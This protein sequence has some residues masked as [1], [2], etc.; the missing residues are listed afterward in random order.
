MRWVLAGIVFALLV[1]LAVVTVAIKAQNVQA[2]ARVE[3]LTFDEQAVYVEW[4]RQAEW[5]HARAQE[6]LLLPR[7]RGA[8]LPPDP[9]E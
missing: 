7:L 5:Y 9:V 1:T 3:R 2:R 8:I 4:A 6:Q